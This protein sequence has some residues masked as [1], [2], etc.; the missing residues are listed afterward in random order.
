MAMPMATLAANTLEFHMYLDPDESPEQLLPS[1]SQ[2][3]QQ[4]QPM[5]REC[6]EHRCLAALLAIRGRLEARLAACLWQ[7]ESFRIALWEASSSPTVGSGPR[8]PG[9]EPHLWGRLGFGDSVDDAWFVVGLLLQ[10]SREQRD[11]TITVR[12]DEGELLLIEAALA[13][14]RWLTPESAHNRVFIRRGAVH[15]IRKPKGATAYPLELSA[16][17]T[18][19]RAGAPAAA[20][21]AAASDAVL[22]RVAAVGRSL[23]CHS[24]H[25]L[26][27]LPAA[28]VIGDG[29]RRA[30]GLIGSCYC[31]IGSLAHSEPDQPSRP[32]RRPRDA[33]PPR[34]QCS[35]Q[36]TLSLISNSLHTFA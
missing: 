4:P 24:A 6:L 14:P 9:T 7:R 11:V 26:L 27:P 21:H 17:L 23:A 18:E 13:I 35:S 8:S 19:L 25:C 34:A 16:A 31:A 3:P 28:Q 32:P 36:L 22:A 1:G 5:H 33:T 29:G 15:I 12:D 30:A 20:A 2:Q 10:L